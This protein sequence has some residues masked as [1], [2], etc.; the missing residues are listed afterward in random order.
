MASP[1]RNNFPESVTAVTHPVSENASSAVSFPAWLQLQWASWAFLTCA[2]GRA[3]LLP[4]SPLLLRWRGEGHLGLGMPKI[5]KTRF[6][7]YLR[8]R[9]T[10]TEK[11][12]WNMLRRHGVLNLKFRRQFVFRGF[13]LDF[14]CHKHNLAIEI[15]GGIH[16]HR[17]HYDAARQAIL[18]R[19]GLKFVRI[20]GEEIELNPEI[21]LDRIRAAIA[22]SKTKS[23]SPPPPSRSELVE[24]GEGGGAL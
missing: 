20:T 16:I 24:G 9:E 10:F 18:E 13:I 14:Y 12:A 17:K 22:S 2:A 7:R 19:E 8:E 21:L 4:P 6:A 3:A 5:A 11:I 23:T 15:D 1:P